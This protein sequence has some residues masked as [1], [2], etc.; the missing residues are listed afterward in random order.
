MGFVV[1]VLMPWRLWR[2]ALV[3]ATVALDYGVGASAANRDI[4]SSDQRPGSIGR[5]HP[6]APG[7]TRLGR[8]ISVL[9]LGDGA[10]LG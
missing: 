8:P 2:W 5:S 4:A 6:P 10:E 1:R 9:P 3:T 7:T